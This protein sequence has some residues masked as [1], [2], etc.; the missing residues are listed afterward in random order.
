MISLLGSACLHG[1]CEEFPALRRTNIT[2][3]MRGTDGVIPSGLS[4]G[5]FEGPFIHVEIQDYCDSGS[6]GLCIR[7]GE[8]V[9]SNEK[10]ALLSGDL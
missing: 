4:F 3:R 1:F 7:P 8:F 5:G 6:L 2:N 9:P 10:D